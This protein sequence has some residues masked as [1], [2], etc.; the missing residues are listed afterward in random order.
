MPPAAPYPEIPDSDEGDWLTEWGGAQR[1]LWSATPEGLVSDLAQAAGGHAIA[2]SHF[3]IPRENL[4]RETRAL[5]NRRSTG[6][7]EVLSKYHRRL[8]SAFDPKGIL[9]PHLSLLEGGQEPDI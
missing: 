9:N 5:D 8:K 6:R 7:S 3:D 4:K 1:W 2:F